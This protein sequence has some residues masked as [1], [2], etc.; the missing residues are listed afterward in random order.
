MD[1]T[2]YSESNLSLLYLGIRHKVAHQ[3]SPNFVID[4]SK[5]RP[6][7]LKD[8]FCGARITWTVSEENFSPP[9]RLFKTPERKLKRDSLPWDVP[10]DH[11]FYV[12]IAGIRADIVKSV[13]TGKGYLGRLSENSK[14]RCN[15]ARAMKDLFPP[16]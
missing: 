9:L 10:Y 13:F 15:F 4:T 7:K 1:K 5:E 2:K 3:S 16:L 6:K 11:R 14:L 12:S 8:E